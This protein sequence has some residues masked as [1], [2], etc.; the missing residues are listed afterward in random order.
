MDTRRFSMLSK[1]YLCVHGYYCYCY[2]CY[3]YCNYSYS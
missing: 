1:T 3:R 2:Y